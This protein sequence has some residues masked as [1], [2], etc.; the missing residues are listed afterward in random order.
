MVAALLGQVLQQVLF[1][2]MSKVQDDPRR[3]AGAYR[4]GVGMISLLV[5]PASAGLYMLA[6][7]LIEL[8]LGPQWA[9]A[10][11]PFRV[12]A[13]ALLVRTTYRVSDALARATGA[14]YRRAWRHWV[15]AAAVVGFAWVG[16]HADLGGVA[17]GVAMGMTV[18]FFLMAQ[19]ATQ[20]STVTWRDVAVSHLGA[21]PSFLVSWVVVGLATSAA[22]DAGLPAPA[23]VSLVLLALTATLWLGVRWMPRRFL[24]PDGVEA[25]GLLFEFAERR[26]PRLLE[27]R[28]VRR[29]LPLPLDSE[30]AR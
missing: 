26:Y 9:S 6:P 7:E 22:R 16:Q 27:N 12:L 30:A 3:L 18:N 29:L 11:T 19:L 2:A 13:L 28:V 14:V 10:V 8:I 21:L 24:G 25:I 4:R 1:P 20:L 23:V 5:L 17:V 15:H